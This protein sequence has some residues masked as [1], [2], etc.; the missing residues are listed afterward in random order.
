MKKLIR[1]AIWLGVLAIVVVLAV[2]AAQPKPVLVDIEEVKQG[3]LEVAIEEDGLTRIKERYVVSTPLAGQLS[4]V[5]LEVGDEV[6]ADRS[7][8][9]MMQANDPSLLDPRSVAQARARVSAAERRLEAAR[10]ENSKAVSTLEF[11]K[12]ELERVKNLSEPIVMTKSEIESTEM[13]FRV[14]TEEFKAASF[15]VEIA[16]YEL[17]LEKAA[18]LLTA[19]EDGQVLTGETGSEKAEVTSPGESHAMEL[20]MKAPIT[21]RILRIYQESSAVLNAGSPIMELGDPLDLEIVVDVLSS[22]AV[23]IAKGDVVWLENWGGEKPLKGEVRVVEPSGFTKLSALGVEEQRVN[24]IIDLIDAP[25][26]RESLGDG[27]RVDARVIIWDSADAVHIPTS[28]L[29][30]IQEEWAVFRVDP[31]N[32]AVRT[33]VEIGQTNGRRAQV[34]DGL[35]SGDR[36]IVHPSDA[37]TDG[38]EVELRD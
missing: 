10:A 38:V 8:I 2:I 7:I 35:A 22:D 37:I 21:G 9:A 4:R 1:P 24:V 6:T 25:E 26:M 5:V 14:R 20:T 3:A 15:R 18:L 16:E 32:T 31:S 17:E 30:R 29:F 36:V 12:L 34:L 28:A 27:F 13:E 23:K 33:V 19:P 11:A